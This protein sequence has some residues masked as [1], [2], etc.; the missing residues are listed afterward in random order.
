MGGIANGL[1][2]AAAAVK[3]LIVPAAGLFL[4]VVG[5]LSFIQGQNWKEAVKENVMK[6]LAGIFIGYLAADIVATF[7]SWV[8]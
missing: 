6:A 1:L 7:I 4:V 2:Q 3:T 5:V 8:S